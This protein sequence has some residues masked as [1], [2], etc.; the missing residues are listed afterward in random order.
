VKA[1]FW[2]VNANETW[3]LVVGD[4]P[5]CTTPCE[6]WVDP[7]MPYALKHD[8]GVFQ[9]NQFVDLPDLRKYAALE[10]MDVRV[11]PRATG[12]F[13]VGILAT[14]LGG[15]SL[16][17]GVVLTSVGCGKGGALCTAGLITM[18]IGAAVA[19]PGIWMIVDSG[20]EIHVTPSGQ[21]SI[22][23]SSINADSAR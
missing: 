8:P 17:T 23:P 4:R 7:A 9:K 20:G 13:V 14:S 10:R 6:R 11:I 21:A 15:M 12:E 22:G 3:E 16:A 5:I 19:A 18:P 2:P 1:R